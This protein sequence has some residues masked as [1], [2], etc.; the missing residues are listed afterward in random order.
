MVVQIVVVIGC[1]IGVVVILFGFMKDRIIIMA[2]FSYFNFIT[3]DL[4]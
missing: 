2:N 1:R 4:F 3:T